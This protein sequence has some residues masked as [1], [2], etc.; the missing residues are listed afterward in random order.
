MAVGEVDFAL[1]LDDETKLAEIDPLDPLDVLCVVPVEI[2]GLD[3]RE[4]RAFRL[5]EFDL[6]PR[7]AVI[8]G[9]R[10]GR[11]HPGCAPHLYPVDPRLFPS[12]I[13]YFLTQIYRAVAE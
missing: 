11:F 5:A 4:Q 12:R 10:L 6:R 13:P 2:I 7:I 3:M 1:A 8:L 9:G